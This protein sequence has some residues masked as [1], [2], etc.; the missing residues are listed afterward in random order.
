MVGEAQSRALLAFLGAQAWGGGG[1]LAV[2]T[3][4]AVR[5][6]GTSFQ[7][8]GCGVTTGIQALL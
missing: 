6:E 7:S 2:V 3:A 8:A 4:L 1:Y 5:A